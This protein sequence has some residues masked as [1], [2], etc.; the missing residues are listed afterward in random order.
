[1]KDVIVVTSGKGGVGKSTIS[2]LMSFQL[3]RDYKVLL[4]DA[5]IGLKNLDLLLKLP[6]THFDISDVIKGRCE[7]EDALINVKE[8]L[9]L[10]TLS[11]SSDVNKYPDYLLE[12][13]VD[14]IRN[15]FD[16]I[17]IDSP[18]GVE[19]GFLNTL[20]VATKAVIVLNDEITSYE[21]S[22]KISRICKSQ[23]IKDLHY[24][25]NRFNGRQFK[26]NELF[27]KIKTMFSSSKISFMPNLRG[28]IFE[29][30]H[31][32]KDCKE[33]KKFISEINKKNNV[34]IK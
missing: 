26:K 8:N 2:L 21:D 24:V 34:V 7:L 30:Y 3:Q 28:D 27:S 12:I 17:I 33:F 23:K 18:A 15:D 29:K 32:I 4:I 6:T 5:D 14:E 1:M 9:F 22:Q 11:L 13:I 16:Y 25:L 20:K 19:R 10:L 31:Q